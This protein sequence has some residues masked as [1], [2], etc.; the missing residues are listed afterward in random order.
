MDGTYVHIFGAI[1]DKA[2]AALTKIYGSDNGDLQAKIRGQRIVCCLD[3]DRVI[4]GFIPCDQWEGPKI[5]DGEFILEKGC[6]CCLG[7]KAHWDGIDSPEQLELFDEISSSK[8]Y[9]EFDLEP[10][11]QFP[12]KP[13]NSALFLCLVEWAW[14]PMHDRLDAYL[15]SRTQDRKFWILWKQCLDGN[16]QWQPSIYCTYNGFYTSHDEASIS[17]LNR[18]WAWERKE[19]ELGRYHFIVDEGALGIREIERIAQTIWPFEEYL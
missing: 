8:D 9:Y 19:Q 7:F 5:E 18:A 12:Q 11:G 3:Q 10:G 2:L 1:A 17:M 16:D 15:V 14:S 4:W 6:V 13:P